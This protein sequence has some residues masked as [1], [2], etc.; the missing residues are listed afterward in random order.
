MFEWTIY[1]FAMSIPNVSNWIAA[2]L[3]HG[4]SGEEK[5]A[6]NKR[7]EKKIFSKLTEKSLN[8]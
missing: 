5:E 7:T 6:E 4:R 2:V 1:I 8:Y 3:E